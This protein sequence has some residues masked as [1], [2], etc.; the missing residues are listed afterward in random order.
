LGGAIAPVAPP[1]LAPWRILNA[2]QNQPDGTRWNQTHIKIIII[3][4]LKT[5]SAFHDVIKVIP[6]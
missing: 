2:Q 6:G 1:G 5:V 4:C 3:N